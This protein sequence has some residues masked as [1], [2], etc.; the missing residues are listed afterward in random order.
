VNPL[1]LLFLHGLTL[2]FGGLSVIENLDVQVQRGSRTAV[3]GPNGAGKTT[4]F[5]LISGVYRPNAGQILFENEAI[6]NVPLSRRVYLGIGRTFQNIRLMKHLTVI[7]NVMLGQ[8]RHV[9]VAARYLLPLNSR[10]NKALLDEAHRALDHAGIRSDAQRL[11][12]GLPYGVQ[13]RIEIARALVTRPKLLMLDEPAAGLN[14]SERIDLLA[15]LRSAISP[16]MTMLIV[17]HDIGFVRSLCGHV[18]ALNFGQKI[19]EGNTDSVCKHP[20]VIE[21]YLGKSDHDV[22][23]PLEKPYRQFRRE[24]GDHAA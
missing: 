10:W 21:A 15:M 24:R 23:V 5:N 13:K 7:E 22:K 3:I 6:E 9:G 4:I 20:A 2:K 19:A 11:A 12:E 18:V 16:D 1:P 14:S 8:H 17:E